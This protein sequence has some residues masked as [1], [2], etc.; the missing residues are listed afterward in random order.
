MEWEDSEEV[1][2]AQTSMFVVMRKGQPRSLSQ[3][4]G[5]PSFVSSTPEPPLV[6]CHKPDQKG[7]SSCPPPPAPQPS[8]GRHN[9]GPSPNPSRWRHRQ[10]HGRKGET[11][12]MQETPE[13]QD[14]G[15][16]LS[17]LL[18]L[19][20][21]SYVRGTCLC[22]SVLSRIDWV[23]TTPYK[24]VERTASKPVGTSPRDQWLRLCTSNSR[25]PGSSPSWG[26]NI[27]HAETKNSHDVTKTL[28]QPNN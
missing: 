22:V 6:F 15:P 23:P 10:P 27:L 7:A 18:P 8:E 19:L 2:G 20:G 5:A 24:L 14:L 11:R 16:L 26:A 28:A 21:P 4:S 25:D 3:I 12:E 1:I 13:G 9:P 17:L